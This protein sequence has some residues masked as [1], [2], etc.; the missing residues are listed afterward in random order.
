[1]IKREQVELGRIKWQRI[2]DTVEHSCIEARGSNYCIE[3]IRER[4]VNYH[5]RLLDGNFV[6]E[7][8]SDI[9]GV[10]AQGVLFEIAG[11]R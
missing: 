11:Y 5:I 6:S 2:S 7:S 10:A 8:W 4:E 1:M 3:I 9:D